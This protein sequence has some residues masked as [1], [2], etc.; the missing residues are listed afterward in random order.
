VT[1]KVSCANYGG[2]LPLFEP[3]ETVYC[4]S[5]IAWRFLSEIPVSA[6][7]DFALQDKGAD[8]SDIRKSKSADCFSILFQA[9]NDSLGHER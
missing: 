4:S 7:S 9:G 8:G 5:L 3:R 6:Q 2:A 1:N